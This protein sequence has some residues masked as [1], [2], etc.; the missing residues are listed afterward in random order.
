MDRIV[1]LHKEYPARSDAA[2]WSELRMARADVP[3]EFAEGLDSGRVVT[4]LE[5]LDRE[6]SLLGTQMVMPE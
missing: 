5:D 4:C 3:A 1:A 6:Q 2:W